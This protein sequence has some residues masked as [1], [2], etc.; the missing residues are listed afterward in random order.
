[1]FDS[2]GGI[3]LETAKQGLYG[4]FALGSIES[5]GQYSGG[6]HV[7]VSRNWLIFL[8]PV[9]GQRKVFEVIRDNIRLRDRIKIAPLPGWS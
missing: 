9:K 3:D 5:A 6:M 1:M 4:K 7:G 2:M 8:G